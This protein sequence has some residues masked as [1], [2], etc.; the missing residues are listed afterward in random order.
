[1]SDNLL[2]GIPNSTLLKVEASWLLASSTDLRVKPRRSRTSRKRLPA[3]T[4]AASIKFPD[5]GS[6]MRGEFPIP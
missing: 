1:M 2:G 6:A 5:F 4:A 3:A